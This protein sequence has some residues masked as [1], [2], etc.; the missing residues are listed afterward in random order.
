MTAKQ[1]VSDCDRKFVL[2][3]PID[4]IVGTLSILECSWIEFDQCVLSRLKVR[5][6]I[7]MGRSAEEI[8]VISFALQRDP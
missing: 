2:P 8:S 5:P 3:A 6:R 1:P 4:L 7:F